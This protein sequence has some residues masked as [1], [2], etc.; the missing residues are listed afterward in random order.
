MEEALRQDLVE[1][2]RR[3]DRLG[4]VAGTE[5]NLSV[6]L[7][8][9]RILITPSGVPKGR[10]DPADLVV[11]ESDGE[12]GM[13]AAHPGPRG[14]GPSSEWRMH[15]ALHL[16]E[17]VGAVV[18]AHPPHA[19]AF[20]AAGRGLDPPA[21]A[22]QPVLL[23]PV[24]LLPFALPS[25][26]EVARGLQRL[27]AECR[28]FLLEKH[29]AVSVGRDVEEAMVRMETLESCARITFLARQID[30]GAGLTRAEREA[31]RGPGGGEG[32]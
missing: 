2:G 15:A 13:R 20:A 14:L 25:T 6:R 5:G 21:V 29:G 18:H 17:E 12:G 4:L 32:A 7:G 27:P 22:E 23:G 3:L 19:T 16:R 11:L 24:P 31:L 28:A 9:Q 26:G 10:M 1:A 30:P 8:P